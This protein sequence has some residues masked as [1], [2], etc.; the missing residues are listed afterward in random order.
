MTERAKVKYN[1]CLEYVLVIIAQVEV[2]NGS[3]MITIIPLYQSLT[4]EI[5]NVARSD[6]ATILA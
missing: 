6:D 1:L 3:D 2:N 5:R 4:C